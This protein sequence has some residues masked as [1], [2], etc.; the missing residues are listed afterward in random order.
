M[1]F[2]D[3]FYN[4]KINVIEA[5]WYRR[6]GSSKSD[7]DWVNHEHHCF[8]LHVVGEALIAD[9]LEQQ[10]WLICINSVD[11]DRDFTLPILQQKEQWECC[12]NTADADV[13]SYAQMSIDALFSMHARSMRVYKKSPK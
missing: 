4:N 8:A 13:T 12:L 6:D 2:E 11:K 10:E 7:I 3:D 9:V 1:S 5:N